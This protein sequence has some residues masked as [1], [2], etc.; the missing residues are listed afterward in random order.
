MHLFL[1]VVEVDQERFLKLK[2]HIYTSFMYYATNSSHFFF[3]FYNI[4]C[5]LS[6]PLYI[7][8]YKMIIKDPSFL[9]KTP[10]K[11]VY[12]GYDVHSLLKNK[13]KKIIKKKLHTKKTT[14]VTFVKKNILGFIVIGCNRCHLPP[15]AIIACCP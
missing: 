1:S 8:I 6:F 11:L 9:T 15:F 5:C 2:V 4:V 12:D 7:Y 14:S 3:F 10:T 13:I